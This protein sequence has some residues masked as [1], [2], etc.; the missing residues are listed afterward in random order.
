M[1]VREAARADGTAS[2]GP[3]QPVTA[4]VAA[5][6]AA[7]QDAGECAVSG[8]RFIG[9]VNTGRQ[10]GNASAGSMAG[11]A[12]V[13]NGTA[14]GRGSAHGNPQ[15]QNC[16][17]AGHGRRSVIR[18]GVPPAHAAP[19]ICLS[20]TDDESPLPIGR[21]TAGNGPGGGV[22]GIPPETMASTSKPNSPA[23][24]T[25]ESS[26]GVMG[27]GSPVALRGFPPAA[28]TGACQ[29]IGAAPLLGDAGEEGSDQACAANGLLIDLTSVRGSSRAAG[30]N[31][32]KAKN[33]AR[34]SPR[35]HLGSQPKNAQFRAPR[36][37]V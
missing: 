23:R 33:P 32:F 27:S 36:R 7:V 37:H 19:H 5:A 28:V 4:A 24:H 11:R 22:C 9:T 17:L 26:H 20:D 18:R 14:G 12:P 10:G 6:Q 30:L 25:R 35:A 13:L 15:P 21:R 29:Q 34:T 31:G 16:P 2:Q 3:T 1:A 8:F